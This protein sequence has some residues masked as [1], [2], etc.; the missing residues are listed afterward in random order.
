MPSPYVILVN[1]D[2]K[3]HGAHM[4]PTWGRKDPG[5][6]YVGHVNL[7]IWEAALHRRIYSDY[8]TPAREIDIENTSVA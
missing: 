2:S 7:A 3:V 4:G 6:P 8:D 1:P 5:R